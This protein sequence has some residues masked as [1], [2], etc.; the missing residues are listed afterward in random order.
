MDAGVSP[1]RSRNRYSP[2]S[3]DTPTTCPS[4]SPV[5]EPLVAGMRAA[6]VPSG[7]PSSVPGSQ[8]LGVYK[9]SGSPAGPVGDSGATAWCERSPVTEPS[10]TSARP[11]TASTTAAPA[12][13]R[14]R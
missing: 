14:R 5:Q 9:R 8:R 12:R 3:A 1:G 11:A 7:P 4:R 6:I 2:V 13:R 10:T